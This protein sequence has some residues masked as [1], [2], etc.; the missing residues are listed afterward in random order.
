[1][2]KIMVIDDAVERGEALEQALTQA[3]YDVIAFAPSATDLHRQVAVL[4]PDV[5][6]ID[7]DSPD[8]DT[9]EHVCV[10]SRD[11]PRPVVMFAHDGDAAKIRA[12]VQAGVSAYVVDGM[13][14]Q[15]I[16]PIIEAA[17]ARFEQYQALRLELKD[18]ETKLAERKIIERAKG[19]LM[20]SR[21]LSEED[22][23]SAL[24]K[25]AMQT[26]AKLVEVA[27]QVVALATLIV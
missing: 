14:A 11:D 21:S 5:I 6:I 8:R 27:R 1:M 22:A 18:S 9:L 26:N 24:R 13:S 15:R 20:K 12:A 16:R 2:L 7:T 25:Q 23:Y 17:V 4:K 10:M 19:L 3:G